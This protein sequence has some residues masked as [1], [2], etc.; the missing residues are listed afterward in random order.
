MRHSYLPNV[1]WEL[2]PA[3]YPPSPEYEKPIRRSDLPAL[4]SHNGPHPPLTARD[5]VPEPLK[6]SIQGYGHSLLSGS[7]ADLR[8]V[9]LLNDELPEALALLS[10][11]L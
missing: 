1:P 4:S 9:P 6:R 11:V 10:E 3:G 2:G 5:C 7:P 8:G